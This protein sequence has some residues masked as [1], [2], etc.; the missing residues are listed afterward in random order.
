MNLVARPLL[1]QQLQRTE[2]EGRAV[3]LDLELGALEQLVPCHRALGHLEPHARP[4]LGLDPLVRRLAGRDQQ[5]L[6]EP[7]LERR[8]L[9]EHEVADVRRV[10]GAAEDAV[11][12]ARDGPYS[13]TWPL[14]WTTYLVV[15]SSRSPIGPRA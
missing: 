2:G 12:A 11:G 13:R 1:T 14:P 15:V 3:A 8:L 6:V 7:E 4:R 5:H 10:E 9:G